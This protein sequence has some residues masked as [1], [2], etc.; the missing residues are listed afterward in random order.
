MG[1]E[2]PGAGVRLRSSREGTVN[3]EE[4]EKGSSWGVGWRPGSLKSNYV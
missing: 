3:S 1:W 2:G 4:E